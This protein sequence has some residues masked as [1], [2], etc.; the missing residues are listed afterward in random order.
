[1]PTFSVLNNEPD[2]RTY[3]AGETIFAEGEK[4][5]FLYYIIEGSV[6]ISRK[7]RIL[8]TLGEGDI[9]GEMALLDESPR[10]ATAVAK[11]DVKAAAVDQKRFLQMVA[12]TPFFA[13]QVMQL[14]AERLRRSN[15]S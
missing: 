11:E 15:E 13:V 8:N 9:F 1:M 12:G 7:G 2:R 6:D 10:S 3:S 4:G 5:D 14:M